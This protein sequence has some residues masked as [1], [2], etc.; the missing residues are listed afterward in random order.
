[1][2][3]KS[4]IEA[5]KDP[6]DGDELVTVNRQS[7]QRLISARRTER[8]IAFAGAA[9]LIVALVIAVVSLTVASDVHTVIDALGGREARADCRS[10]LAARYDLAQVE[11]LDKITRATTRGQANAALAPLRDIAHARGSRFPCRAE[12]RLTTTTTSTTTT[13]GREP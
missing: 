10:S 8:G 6:K 11:W 5:L 1:M 7:L 3:P 2:S 9:V 12:R 13:T 4:V